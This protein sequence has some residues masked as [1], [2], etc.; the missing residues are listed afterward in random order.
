MTE[1]TNGQTGAPP[2]SARAGLLKA[3]EA[4]A[5][6]LTTFRRSGEGVVTP[7]WAAVVDERVFFST[8]ISR[9]KV[10]RIAHT[11]KVTVAPGTQRGK[12]TGDAVP[13]I[14]HL[15]DDP[16]LDQRFQKAIRRRHPVTGR[17]IGVFYLLRRSSE[18]LLYELSPLEA[19]VE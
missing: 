3:A 13:A 7:V 18:H 2:G 10:K 11:P 6:V 15:V 12:P 19:G 9:V 16:D 5:I 14:A 8:E 1:E 17:L 4:P